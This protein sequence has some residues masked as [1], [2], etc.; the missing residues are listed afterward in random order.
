MAPPRTGSPRWTWQGS[1]A[2][3]PWPRRGPPHLRRDDAERYQVRGGEWRRSARGRHDLGPVY[4]GG[5]G[6]PHQRRGHGFIGIRPHLHRDHVRRPQVLGGQL[7]RSA[8]GQHDHR[9]THAGRRYRAHGR[10]GRRIIGRKTHLCSDED[11]RLQML[12]E[13]LLRSAWGR[14]HRVPDSAG[15][16]GMADQKYGYCVAGRP[17]H[18]RRYRL[19]P[20]QMLGSQIFGPSWGRHDGGPNDA[21][22]R[23]RAHQRRGRRLI[24]G[25]S[26]LRGDDGRRPEVLGEQL[27]RSTWGRHDHEPAYTGGRGW[28]HQWR[29]RRL[30]GR[31][32][33]LRCDHD[34]RP[35][36]LGE[37]LLRSAWDRAN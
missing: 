18:L 8:R 29:G 16:R 9:P 23:G 30:I 6:R 26:R 34:R 31:K 1:P 17:I 36:M 10:C 24:G 25:E 11:G 12:G 3:W 19:R 28:A 27:L 21:G 4:G 2:V 22:E 37:Q 32:T 35:Q 13:Q 15:G 14:Q 5:R 33:H 7:L 20:D